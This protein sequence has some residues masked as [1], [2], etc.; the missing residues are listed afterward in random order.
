MTGETQQRSRQTRAVSAAVFLALFALFGYFLR[1]AIGPPLLYYQHCPVFLTGADYL[2]GFLGRPGGLAEYATLFL[3]QFTFHPWAGTVVITGVTVLV[4]LCTR[5]ILVAARG[6]RVHPALWYL[7]A[8]L[9]LML[10]GQYDYKLM[11]SVSLL[12][13]LACAV[14]WMKLPLGGTLRRLALF[15]VAAVVLYG[16]VGGMVVLF[17]VVCGVFEWVRHRRVVAGVVCM[18]FAAALPGAF[19]LVSYEIGALEA[20]APLLPFRIGVVLRY[21]A[22]LTV[23]GVPPLELLS[24]LMTLRLVL[25]LFFPLAMV[26]S[27]NRHR[28]VRLWR[29]IARR[30]AAVATGKPRW[31]VLSLIPFLI[32]SVVLVSWTHDRVRKKQLR[33]GYYAQHRNWKGVLMVASSLPPERHDSYV[34]HEVA[35]GL[36]HAG[37]L[38]DKLFAFPQKVGVD[39]LM[40]SGL[41]ESFHDAML[42]KNSALWLEL[43]AMNCAHRSAHIAHELYGDRPEL[44][45]RLVRIHLLEGDVELARILLRRL[46]RNPVQRASAEAWLERI[47]DGS[48]ME[49]DEVLRLA[50]SRMLTPAAGPTRLTPPEARLERLLAEHK[51]NRMAFEYLMAYH[52]LCSAWLPA[53]LDKAAQALG[54]LDD[55]RDEKTG[56]PYYRGIPQH[57]AEAMI[58]RESQGKGLPAVLAHRKLDEKARAQFADFQRRLA[59]FRSATDPD[60]KSEAQRTLVNSHASSYFFYREFLYSVAPVLE[61]VETP[62]AHR[63]LASVLAR[64]RKYDK[65]LGHYRKAF[66]LAG[67]VDGQ[68]HA[69]IGYC[70]LHLGRLDESVAASRRAVAINPKSAAAYRNLADA[71]ELQGTFAESI[72]TLTQALE[73]IPEDLGLRSDLAGVLATAPYAHL[74]DGSRALRLAEAVCWETDSPTPQM[75]DVLAA[76]YAET[77]RFKSAAET[78]RQAASLARET[79]NA[80]LAQEIDR[81]RALYLKGIPFR[82]AP[83]RT[84]LPPK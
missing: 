56:G 14:G 50:S 34:M 25:F 46:K 26:A 35:K 45:K 63:K 41:W 75:L 47:D 54:R 13:T 48:L 18:L 69:G 39:S 71:L 83:P 73:L 17:G 29:R 58:V 52:L 1:Y 84:G 60:A 22:H 5:A 66:S 8:V 72:R 68:V 82:I 42:L 64:Q 15:P 67:D 77:G 51:D 62:A 7:P 74:R 31:T 4:C 40:P 9:L 79:G 24:R 21:S 20:Y 2:K 11:T 65:A 27:A 30:P 32:V 37:R 80:A 61:T 78:A 76:A 19:A 81:R 10:H 23:P 55:F 44:L 49:S 57:Y 70:L 53:C 43:G 59:L 3:D 16:L 12:V 36:Y 38:P 33:V 28:W 6:E